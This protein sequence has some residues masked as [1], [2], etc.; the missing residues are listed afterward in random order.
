[1]F[2]LKEYITAKSLQEAYELLNKNK[3]NVV[4]GG[5][6]WLK[7]GNKNYNMGIDLSQLGLDTII[8]NESQI[9][10]GCMTTLRQIETSSVLNTYF[11]GIV[12]GS[13]KDI[14]GVQFRNCA[15]MGGS[16][17]SRFGFSDLLTAL[18]A[19]DTY[20][21]MHAGGTIPLEKFINMPYQKDILVKIV[22]KKNGCQASYNSHRMTATDFPILAVAI[23]RCATN[24]K[25][26][27]GA[28][29]NKAALATRASTLLPQ[30]PTKEDIESACEAV[31]HELN[32]GTNL[33]GSAAY[34]KQLAKVLVKRGVEEICR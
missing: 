17:Y 6:L 5:L 28:R 33:R 4:L 20:V 10:I 25:I 3:N 22:I 7:M 2:S 14:V 15:T 18:L 16:V 9:E 13:V 34:R 27:V 1:M 19:L 11:D 21:H 8:E 29:P 23:S 26:A 24:W 31:T 30:N 32:F 12:A